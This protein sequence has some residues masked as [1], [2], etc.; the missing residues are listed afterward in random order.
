MIE[1]D[2]EGQLNRTTDQTESS[3]MFP[4]I[5]KLRE[6]LL[7]TWERLEEQAHRIGVEPFGVKQ[8][9]LLDGMVDRAH[10]VDNLLQAL[11]KAIKAL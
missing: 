5:T 1:G 7:F 6:Q 8:Q 9:D 10:E 3:N 2:I 4:E 11:K